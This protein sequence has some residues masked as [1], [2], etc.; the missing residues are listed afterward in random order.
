MRHVRGLCHNT[1]MEHAMGDSVAPKNTKEE[2]EMKLWVRCARGLQVVYF[3]LRHRGC[4]IVSPTTWAK[5]VPRVARGQK[6]FQS[7]GPH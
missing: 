2:G 1:L 7:L 3:T 5:R 4:T 6:G